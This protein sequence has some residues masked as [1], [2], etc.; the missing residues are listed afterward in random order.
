MP[1]SYPSGVKSFTTKNAGDPIQPSHVNDLQDEVAAIEA[2][3]LNGTGPFSAGAT[4]LASANVTG[5]STLGSLSVTG[6][7]TLA[8]VTAG[9]STLGSLSVAGGSTLGT[10]SAGASTLG[11]LNVAGG[12]TLGTVN[13][14]AS[15]L[16]SLSVTGDSTLAAVKA[17]T[18]D[19]SGL[20]T[21]T[22][23]VTVAGTLNALTI[24]STS[25][26]TMIGVTSYARAYLGAVQQISSAAGVVVGFEAKDADLLSE[27]STTTFTFTP[28]AAGYYQVAARSYSTTAYDKAYTLGIY[29]NG[30]VA[31]EATGQA[32]GAPVTVNVG[33]LLALSSGSSGAVTTRIY[34]P[35]STARLSTGLAVTSFEILR[36]F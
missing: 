2:G 6:G 18:L 32:A 5:G 13:A 34:H 1:A 33:G 4:T 7:S 21:F 17:T 8:A 28:K 20:S 11:S 23:T 19:V 9:A 26:P 24:V 3:L 31:I 35:W 16:A 12:S 15:T 27:Y 29:V 22:G 30:T 25:L 10:V 36:I 14:G